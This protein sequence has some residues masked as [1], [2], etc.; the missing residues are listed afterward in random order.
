MK[1]ELKKEDFFSIFPK[2]KDCFPNN[3]FRIMNLN[4]QMKLYRI[5]FFNSYNVQTI[6]GSYQKK[7]VIFTILAIINFFLFLC[8]GF[9]LVMFC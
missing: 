2:S 5:L 6:I 7:F 1:E 8:F 3:E 9:F 4:T